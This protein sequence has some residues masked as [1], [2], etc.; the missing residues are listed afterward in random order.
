MFEWSDE[1]GIGISSIDAQHRALFGI[2]R[3]LHTAMAGGQAKTVL[4]SILDRLVQYTKMHFAH[5]EHLMSQHHYPDL[6][7]HLAEHAALTRQVMQFQQDFRSGKVLITIQL[8]S[9]LKEWLVN[10]IRQ[11]DRKYAPH[12]KS[13]RVA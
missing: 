5:E 8:L 1:F 7:A 12:L 11:E 4:A 9:F 3:E 10:H 13:Q 2:A 6:Q